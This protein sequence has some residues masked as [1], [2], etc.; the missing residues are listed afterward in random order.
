MTLRHCL[1]AV[2]AVCAST[3]MLEG[4][5]AATDF[6]QTVINQNLSTGDTIETTDDGAIFPAP[7]GHGYY[8]IGTSE[9]AAGSNAITTHGAA[10]HGIYVNAAGQNS[11]VT[12]NGTG[13]TITTNAA[14]SFGV[15]IDTTAG[16]TG[17][18]TLNDVAIITNGEGAIGFNVSGSGTTLTMTGGSIETTN[19]TGNKSVGGLVS[20]GATVNITDT[21]IQTHQAGAPGLSLTNGTANIG[22]AAQII[23]HAPSAPGIVLF[24]NSTLNTTGAV[25]VKAEGDG[26]HAIQ[27]QGAA[28]T[29]TLNGTTLATSGQKAA[30]LYFENRAATTATVDATGVI[31]TTSKA[32]S[33]GVQFFGNQASTNQVKFDATST[34]TTTGAG[35]HAVSV[36]SGS[37][38][39]IGTVAGPG[40][41]VLPNTGSNISF[42]GPGSALAHVGDAGS[43][44]TI[45]GAGLPANVKLTDG[46]TWGVIADNG[47]K[48]VFMTAATAQGYG[49]WAHGTTGTATLEFH[50]TSTAA[51]SLVKVDSGGL[52]DLTTSTLGSFPIAA[53]AGT[54]SGN[55]T[56]GTNTLVI[57]GS[58]TNTYEG[59]IAGSGG[60]TRDGTGTTILTGK[61]TY[62]GGTNLIGGVLSV[63]ADGNLG[64][65]SGALN[66]DGG[67]LQVTGT[68]FNGTPRTITWGASGGGFN[69]ADAANTFTVAQVL[70]PGAGGLNV[71]PLGG[72]GTLELTAA[73]TYTGPTNINAGALLLN[74]SITS[75]TTVSAGAKLAGNGTVTGDVANA[76][77]VAPGG[78][79]PSLG[80]KLTID[81]NYVGTGNAQLNIATQLGNENSPTTQLVISGASGAGHKAS[82]VTGIVVTNVGGKGA[83]TDGKGI[84]IV[85]TTAGATSDPGAFKLNGTVAAGSYGYL[86]FQGPGTAVG[87]AEDVTSWFL[88]SHVEGTNGQPDQPLYRGET[89]MHAVYGAMARQLG[90]LALGTF[91]DRNGDQ[92][93]A[94]TGGRER[95]WGRIYGQRMEQ[96]NSGDVRPHFEGDFAGLQSGVDLWQFASLP[97]HRDNVGMFVAY[98][99]GRAD[100]SGF[101]LATPNMRVGRTDFDATSLGA[102]WSHI[103]PT[104]WYTDA[105]VMGTLYDGD[106][107]TSAAKVGVEGSGVIASLEGGVTLARFA[108]MKLEPQ[109]QLVYQYI[110]LDEANDPFSHVSHRTPDA[111]HGRLG[112]RLAADSLPWLLRPYLKAN[113][114]QD[115]VGSDRAVYEQVHELVA[116]NRATTL[117]LGGGVTA[118][119]APNVG[120]WASADWSTDMGGNEQERESV[121]GTAG[122]R[123]TW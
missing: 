30:A 119:I 107:R 57:N 82:G 122:L 27:M 74:G 83:P 87:T 121:R 1:I 4:G 69:I 12:V 72:Q 73:N 45:T 23:T 3:W 8:I 19:T 34:I 97:G 13:N 117:E 95:A 94:D 6:N 81:G 26:G 39:T 37:A 22:G 67:T 59:V 78:I 49:L 47:G 70:G 91:H 15:F 21:V 25:V 86:L 80:Q 96:T 103:A 62:S 84:P 50:D 102:Y 58:T 99:E 112:L 76:G 11:D 120:L 32:G 89:A 46:Q 85:V 113:V 53:L 54:G 71:N 31:I 114:W 79:P 42:T 66:F 68:T 90:L 35:A 18:A 92:R 2:A 118:Q 77:I 110:N 52:L 123:I 48:A 65:A 43:V 5:A 104:G 106:G 93:L 10:A 88:R 101:V 20:A 61:N 33:H 36:D 17:T 100:V 38:I 111:L 75:D 24:P 9:T 108:G 14:G 98:T 109:A 29:A 41:L 115:F 40:V 64:D 28:V 7:R 63:S 56:L 51:G 116:R 60:L 105:V 55:V 44:L 16:F